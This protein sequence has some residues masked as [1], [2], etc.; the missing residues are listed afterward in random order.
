MNDDGIYAVF[1]ND[2]EKVV[3]FSATLLFFQNNY[4][5]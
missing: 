1:Q 2:T 5:E 4:M 3:Q